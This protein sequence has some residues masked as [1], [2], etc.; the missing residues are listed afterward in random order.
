MSTAVIINN[1]N[2]MI[3]GINESSSIIRNV[4]FSENNDYKPQSILHYP[5]T[6]E[7]DI[8]T[9]SNSMSLSTSL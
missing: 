2:P 8:L 6:S 4:S 7:S 3:N 5:T 9:I 1:Y